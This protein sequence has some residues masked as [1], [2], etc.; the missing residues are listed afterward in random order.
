MIKDCGLLLVEYIVAH[1]SS[2]VSTKT[3]HYSCC[4]H[5]IINAVAIWGG[6]DTLRLYSFKI[7][8]E[9]TRKSLA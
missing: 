8:I 5:T 3:M 7:A 2:I 9:K 6:Y 4:T 1:Y